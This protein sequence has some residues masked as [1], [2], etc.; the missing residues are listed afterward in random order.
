MEQSPSLEANSR[1]ATHEIPHC[2]GTRKFI[3][4]FRRLRHCT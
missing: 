1:S 4:V 3:T 2:Y